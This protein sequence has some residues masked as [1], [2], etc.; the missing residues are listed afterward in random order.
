M[1]LQQPL[2]IDEDDELIRAQ[3][4]ADRIARLRRMRKARR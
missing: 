2:E 1:T 4:I 3:G